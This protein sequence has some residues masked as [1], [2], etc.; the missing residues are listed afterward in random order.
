MKYEIGDMLRYKQYSGMTLFISGYS[1]L[2]FTTSGDILMFSP[3]V[4]PFGHGWEIV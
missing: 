4:A 3:K 2:Y 1:H